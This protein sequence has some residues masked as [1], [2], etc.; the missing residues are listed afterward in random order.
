MR[1]VPGATQHG[2]SR[3]RGRGMM[4]MIDWAVGNDQLLLPIL[5]VTLTAA[6]AGSALLTANCLERT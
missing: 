3:K 4:P 1:V 5:T 2:G 6:L